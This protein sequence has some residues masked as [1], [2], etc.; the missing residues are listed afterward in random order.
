[1]KIDR[2]ACTGCELCHPYCP[3]GA[4]AAVE[5]DE[6]MVSE[7]DQEACVECGVC[8]K[9]DV[10]PTEAIYQPELEWPRLLRAA[11][12]NPMARHPSSGAGGRGTMEMKTNDVTGRYRVGFAGLGIEMGRPGIGTSFRDLQTVSMALAELGVAFEPD[13]PVTATMVDAKAGKFSDE[14]LDERVLSAIIEFKVETDRLKEVLETVKE[15]STKI[16]TVFSM[17]L[18]SRVGEKGSLPNAEIAKR[19]GFSLRPNTKTNIGLGRPL[20]KEVSS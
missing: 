3:V 6:E 15:V 17:G 13:N 8:L 4:I 5:Q 18:I 12:S 16:N 10:C 20:F 7:V 9:V 19:A 2:D 14:V 1:M 11:F